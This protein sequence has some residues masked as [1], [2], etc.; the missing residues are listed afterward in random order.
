MIPC[1]LAI[2]HRS[3][4]RTHCLHFYSEE[5]GSVFLRNARNS[6]ITQTSSPNISVGGRINTVLTIS[7]EENAVQFFHSAANRPSWSGCPRRLPS[8]LY[9]ASS[10]HCAFHSQRKECSTTKILWQNKKIHLQAQR[11]L[12]L[13]QTDPVHILKVHDEVET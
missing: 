10:L 9:R 13:K 8:F 7:A 2:S 11:K 1:N 4:V 5:G 12:Y 6:V 3:F